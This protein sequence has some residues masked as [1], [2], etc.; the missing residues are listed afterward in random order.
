MIS[1]KYI[2]R[3][4]GVIFFTAHVVICSKKREKK[5]ERKIKTMWISQILQ[6]HENTDCK[7]ILAKK[8]HLKLL[9]NFNFYTF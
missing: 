7:R 9:Y 5:W 2:K 3:L 1:V 4:Y 8:Y 6:V